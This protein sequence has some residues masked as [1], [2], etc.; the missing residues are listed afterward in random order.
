MQRRAWLIQKAIDGHVLNGELE[1]V[2]SDDRRLLR[3]I[4]RSKP[5]NRRKT[6]E[7]HLSSL[8]HE[9][10]EWLSQAILASDA[11]DPDPDMVANGLDLLKQ[12]AELSWLWRGWIPFGLLSM[13]AGSPGIGKSSFVLDALGRPVMMGANWPDGLRGPKTPGS[14]MW[15][16]TEASQGILAHRIRKWRLPGARIIS[17]FDDFTRSI[18]LESAEDL[19]ELRESI[20]VQRPL[21]PSPF[22]SR[23]QSRPGTGRPA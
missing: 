5:E 10:K 17:P 11:A 16:D 3:G 14:V 4:L 2:D 23:L 15:V 6:L 18:S 1:R 8:D 19:D 12:A 22:L 9:E 20:R 7:R 13:V 21:Q